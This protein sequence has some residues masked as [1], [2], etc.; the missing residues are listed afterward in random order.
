VINVLENVN[1]SN[2][3]EPKCKQDG[4]VRQAT[5]KSFPPTVTRYSTSED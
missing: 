5:I 4:G 2:V 1:K 3:A